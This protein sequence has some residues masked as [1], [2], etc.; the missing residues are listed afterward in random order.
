MPH[1]YLPSDHT[2]ADLVLAADVAMA[3]SSAELY[4]T[5]TID[6]GQG[7]PEVMA[8]LHDERQAADRGPFAALVLAVVRGIG[9]VWRSIAGTTPPHSA[10]PHVSQDTP[11]V[12][13]EPSL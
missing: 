7:A 13:G 3:V 9:A 10:P 12:E 8:V 2:D 4:V 11:R 5:W 6:D 1:L